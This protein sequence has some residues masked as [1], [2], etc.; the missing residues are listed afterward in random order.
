MREAW[1]ADGKFHDCIVVGVLREEWSAR[2]ESLHSELA[3]SIEILL[4]APG[5]ERET[6]MSRNEG[7]GEAG[8]G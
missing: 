6:V 5:A 7:Q 2:R 8:S 3:T 4:Q 1:F